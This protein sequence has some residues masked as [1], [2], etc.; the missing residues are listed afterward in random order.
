MHLAVLTNYIMFALSVAVLIT[1]VAA[2][3]NAA[4]QRPD[5]YTATGKLT[6]P[7]WLA[8]LGGAILLAVLGI[9]GG[10]VFAAAIAAAAAGVYLADVRPKL[11]EIQ[12]KR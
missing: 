10:S 12:G 2:F 11:L 6:K 4:T 8:I 1:A 9:Y 3:G 7:T 5:A